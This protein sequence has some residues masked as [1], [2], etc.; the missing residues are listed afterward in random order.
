MNPRSVA[1][2]GGEWADEV[3]RQLRRSDYKGEVWRVHPRARSVEG[4]EV[5]TAIEELPHAPDAAFVAVRADLAVETIGQLSAIGCGGAVCF[6]A[7][8]DELD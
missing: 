3:V 4:A 6:A 8:F 1:I 5:F 2:F 7:G